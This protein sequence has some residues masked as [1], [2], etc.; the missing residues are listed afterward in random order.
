[1]ASIDSTTAILV[2][3]TNAARLLK[4]LCEQADFARAMQMELKFSDKLI[5]ILNNMEDEACQ[6]QKLM[7]Q[8]FGYVGPTGKMLNV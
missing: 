1:M 6:A 3:G 2:S 8:S 4:T 7:L 5:A